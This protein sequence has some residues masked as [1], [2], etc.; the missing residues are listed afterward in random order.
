MK[1]CPHCQGTGYAVSEVQPITM[2]E[3]VH[4]YRSLGIIF[5][6]LKDAKHPVHWTFLAEHTG[7]IECRTDPYKAMQTLMCHLR[8]R[9]RGTSWKIRTDYK[10]GYVLEKKNAATKQVA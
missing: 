6:V 10:V 7:T 2:V 3:G 1:V 9:L 5:A 8:K 4:L